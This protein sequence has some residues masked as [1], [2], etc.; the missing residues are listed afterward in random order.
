[1]LIVPEALIASLV[2]AKTHFAPSRPVSPRWHGA[3]QL[4]VVREAWARGGSMAS[5]PASTG[6]RAAG[7]EGGRLLSR[8]CGE[9]G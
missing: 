3:M 7:G 8:K 4:P 9:G 6:R 1:M 2:T 5:S